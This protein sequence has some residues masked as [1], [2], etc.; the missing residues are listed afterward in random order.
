MEHYTSALTE[1]SKY[2]DKKTNR[3]PMDEL[4]D[5]LKNLFIAINN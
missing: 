3:N 2:I 5:K 4:N 1:L